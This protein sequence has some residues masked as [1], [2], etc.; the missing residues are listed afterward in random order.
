MSWVHDWVFYGNLL[1][2]AEKSPEKIHDQIL[3]TMLDSLEWINFYSENDKQER[4]L[5]STGMATQKATNKLMHHACAAF[6][7]HLLLKD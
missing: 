3:S 7:W 5:E 4:Q 6:E 1:K 2:L